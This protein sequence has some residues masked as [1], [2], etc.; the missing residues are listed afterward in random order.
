MDDITKAN[1]ILEN[2]FVFDEDGDMERCLLIG[3]NDPLDWNFS[4][5]SDPEWTFMLN[6]FTYLELLTRVYRKT[7]EIKYINHGKYLIENWIENVELVPSHMTRTLDTGMRIYH[8]IEFALNNKDL[9][10]SDFFE[11][12]N[13]SIKN[14]VIFLDQNYLKRHFLSNWGLVQKIGIAVAGLYLV[15]NNMYESAIADLDKMI[16][17]QYIDGGYIHW[18]RCIGYHNFMILWLLRLNEYEQKYGKELSFKNQ[19]KKMIETTEITTDLFGSQINNGDSDLTKTVFLINKYERL[20]K[21]KVNCKHEK[22]FKS[23]GLY[24]KKQ[25]DSMLSCYNQSMSSNHSHADFTHFNYINKDFKILDGGRYTY[26]ETNKREYYKIYAHN[27]LIIDGESSM[28]YVS[29]WETSAYP[30]INPIYVYDGKNT[31]IEMSYFDPKRSLFVKR[32]IIYTKNNDLIVFDHIECQGEHTVVTNLLVENYQEKY[33]K[34][35]NKFT[36]EDSYYSPL[37]NI[38]K[39]CQKIIISEKFKNEYTQ[40]MIFGSA[41]GYNINKVKRNLKPLSYNIA[42]YAEKNGQYYVNI[43]KEISDSPKTLEVGDYI[44][45]GRTCSI[46]DDGGIEIYR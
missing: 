46:F 23:Y 26:T 14:Q 1:L 17:A 7:S 10:S 43:F 24:V 6:R 27:N 21:T 22:L 45:Y 39:S 2:K 9:L 3:S 34:T 30:T 42:M 8:F 44:F 4:L 13:K 5:N 20:Y 36:I 15:D 32:R 28:G 16:R 12:L 11:T 38:E 25:N 37:Y 33:F 31:F 19:I 35:D 41:E 18:E 40:L 29:S